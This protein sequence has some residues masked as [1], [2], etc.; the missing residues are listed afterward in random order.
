MPM[1]KEEYL[2]SRRQLH[3]I[4]GLWKLSPVPEVFKR[5]E[6][7]SYTTRGFQRDQGLDDNHADRFFALYV[8]LKDSVHLVREKSR[9]VPPTFMERISKETASVLGKHWGTLETN[10]PV[11]IKWVRDKERIRAECGPVTD[12]ETKSYGRRLSR[13]SSPGEPVTLFI[14]RGWGRNTASIRGLL[15]KR[16]GLT[17]LP[18]HSEAV[19]EDN[20]ATYF[21]IVRCELGKLKTMPEP[22]VTTTYIGFQFADF[23]FG[24]TLM[25]CRANLARLTA[26][27]LIKR[28]S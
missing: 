10:A 19:G 27:A 14:R 8:E 18:L 6:K 11:S 1:T 20:G 5:K 26:R 25:A 21:R 16:A 28:L 24:D 2:K 7:Y 12:A 15:P 13:R 9:E 23:A 22:K 4:H 17:W 3:F